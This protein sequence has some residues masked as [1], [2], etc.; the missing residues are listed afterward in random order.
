V[1]IHRPDLLFLLKR[2]RLNG[3]S[4]YISSF[5]LVSPFKTKRQMKKFNLLLLSVLAA[6]VLSAQTWSLDKNHAKLGFQVTHLLISDVKVP[7]TLLMLLSPLL[8]M[9]SVML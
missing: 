9:T 8:K 4:F 2:I 7:L 6:G 5:K 3:I 1:I